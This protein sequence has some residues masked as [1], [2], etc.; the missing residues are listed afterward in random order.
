MA[1]KESGM[2]Q[3]RVYLAG[4]IH[5]GWRGELEDAAREAGLPV[6]FSSP[7]QDHTA[8]DDVGTAILGAEERTSWRD[9][10]G[11]Q[12][13]AIRARTLVND[14]DLIVVRFA[15]GEE[16][17]A[18]Y[19]QWNAAF[20]AGYAAALGKPIIALHAEA[21]AHALKELDAAT[22]AVASTIEQVIEILSYV[23]G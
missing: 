14:A 23:T 1:G 20:D 8:S 11:A 21:G 13:N 17:G 2:R 18:S 9:R 4:E 5:T 3:W 7:V 10:K 6:A 12:I 22:L 19:R 15:M 16:S